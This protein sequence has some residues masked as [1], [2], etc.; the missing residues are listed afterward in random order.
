[1]CTHVFF[2]VLCCEACHNVI[3]V[4]T[5]HYETANTN[6]FIIA[7]LKY[8]LVSNSATDHLSCYY[9]FFFFFEWTSR[10]PREQSQPRRYSNPCHLDNATVNFNN[11]S[12]FFKVCVRSDMAPSPPSSTDE[13]LQHHHLESLS[14]ASI[15][16]T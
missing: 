9:F 16:V 1:M 14:K 6:Y 2:F 7:E 4:D 10:A 5:Q 11:N 12:L 13:S 3:Q 15:I 8:L